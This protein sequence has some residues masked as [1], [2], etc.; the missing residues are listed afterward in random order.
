MILE[1]Y[2]SDYTKALEQLIVR[3]ATELYSKKRETAEKW[4][5]IF[6]N[7]KSE[8]CRLMGVEFLH[9]SIFLDCKSFENYFE[10]VEANFCDNKVLWEALIPVYAQYLLNKNNDL[11]KESFKK[12]LY[13]IKDSYLREKRIFLQSI[14]YYIQKS[15]DIVDVI[16]KITNVSFEKDSQI[17]QQL[18]YYLEYKFKE[19]TN[20]AIKK[21]YDIYNINLYKD[22]KSVV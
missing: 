16:D 8:H 1:K 21:L 10:F 15:Q 13:E 3:I 22:R 11:Y 18:D 20:T 9:R 6:L 2:T 17:L 4:L 5:D 12:R 19:D 14:M 7:E